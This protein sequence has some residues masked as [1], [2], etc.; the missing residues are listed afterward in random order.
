[1]EKLKKVGLP[2]ILGL[3]LIIAGIITLTN[4]N[5]AAN[6]LAII[7]GWISIVIGIL[8]ILL[9]ITQSAHLLTILGAVI[10]IVGIIIVSKP[11]SFLKW[12]G[13]I[14]GIWFI[15]SGLIGIIRNIKVAKLF[16]IQFGLHILILIGGI[17][18]VASN[19][20]FANAIGIIIGVWLI[21]YGI[22]YLVFA[23]QKD[24]PD[25]YIEE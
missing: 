4:P 6:T 24:Q 11:A 2:A 15:I 16:P 23:F 10:F 12:L 18:L 19:W 3:I 22:A 8:M 9:G 25:V 13:L 20:L 14:I 21:I 17:M 5:S 1:M 7:I